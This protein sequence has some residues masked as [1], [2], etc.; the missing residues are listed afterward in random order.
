MSLLAALGTLAGIE[1]G[2]RRKRGMPQF[3][4]QSGV[5]GISDTPDPDTAIRVRPD[6]ALQRDL[7]SRRAGLS[8]APWTRRGYQTCI[9]WIET[10]RTVASFTRTL[11]VVNSRLT[12]LHFAPRPTALVR[13]SILTNAKRSSLP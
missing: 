13:K 10:P 3:A 12:D 9:A 6:V 7:M 11:F 4:A 8:G 1:C 5:R 2:A